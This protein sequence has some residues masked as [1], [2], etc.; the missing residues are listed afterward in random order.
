MKKLFSFKKAYIFVMIQAI[1]FSRNDLVFGS[2]A[3]EHEKRTYHE[4]TACS[5]KEIAF[6]ITFN[7]KH[8]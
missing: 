4:L 5:F 2:V 7:K 6:F 3:T 8:T 1:F